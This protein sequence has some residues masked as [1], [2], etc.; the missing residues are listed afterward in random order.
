[1]INYIIKRLLLSIPTIFG[2]IFIVMLTIEL[3]PGDPVELMLGEHATKEAVEN[4]RTALGLD[5]P[6][7]TRYFMYLKNLTKGDMGRSIRENRLVSKEISDVWP[8]TL[9]LTIAAMVIALS[10]GVM[11]GIFSAVKPNSYFDGTNRIISLFGLSMPVFWIGLVMIVI[12]AYWLRL[13][14][15]GGTGSWKH[16][17]LPAVTLSLPSIA[18]ISRMTRSS[19]LEV[20]KEDYVRTAR[21]KGLSEKVVILKHALKNALIPIVTL[22]GLQLGQL[23]GGAILTETVFAWPGLGRLMIRAIFARDYILLQGTVLVFALAFVLIN[24][25]VDLSYSFLDP[26]VSYK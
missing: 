9:K 8:A 4:V 18:M 2:V 12:F 7:L 5:K 1:M 26:R 16:I 13:L 11:L 19:L 3:V 10:M 15:T 23:M 6:L 25:I 24:L 14:P 22:S 20:L 17:V 21:A